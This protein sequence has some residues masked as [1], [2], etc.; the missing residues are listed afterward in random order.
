MN[1]EEAIAVAVG[2]TVAIAFLA[3]YLFAAGVPFISGF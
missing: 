1:L 3:F 2:I